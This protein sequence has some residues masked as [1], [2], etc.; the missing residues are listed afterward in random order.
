[1][2][3]RQHDRFSTYF[4]P[5]SVSFSGEAQGVGKL[6]DISYGGCKVES[7]TRPS[8]GAS[9]TLR[10]RIAKAEQPIVIQAGAVAWTV[11]KKYF[12]VR[13]VSL[14]PYEERAL[15]RYLTLVNDSFLPSPDQQTG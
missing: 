6:Y 11:P 2:L 12:G 5:V 1:M 9:V 4:D 3:P 8:I 13:F 10:F 15:N 7:G 14:E